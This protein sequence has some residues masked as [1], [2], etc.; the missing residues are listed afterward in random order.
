MDIGYKKVVNETDGGGINLP[1][2]VFI[3]FNV[4]VHFS[5]SSN[6]DPDFDI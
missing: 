2:N 3:F 1:L 4:L 5:L 6:D